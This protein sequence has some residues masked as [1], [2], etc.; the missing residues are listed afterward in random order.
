MP[1]GQPARRPYELCALSTLRD[2]LRSGDLYLANSRQY[3]DPETFLIPRA[4]WPTLREDVCQQLDL[5]PTGATRLSDR[6]QALK[7]L[8]PRVDRVLDRSDGIRIEHGELIVPMDEG[9]D[10]PES[11]QA[12]DAQISRRI[13]HVDLTDL[14]FCRKVAFS[15]VWESGHWFSF[16]GT[17]LPFEI[18]ASAI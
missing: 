13:P 1:N 7:D 16:M 14:R 9:E 12:L 15:R 11:V 6:A 2:T 17:V 10:L 5:D 18:I 8:L 3:T 4:T